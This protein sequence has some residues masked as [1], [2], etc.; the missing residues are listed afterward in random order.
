MVAAILAVLGLFV[1][2]TML[3]PTIRYLLAGEGTVGRVISALG[4][5]DEAPPLSPLGARAGR[6]LANLQEALPVFLTVALL[7]V[8]HGSGEGTATLGAWWFLA[9]R[10]LYVPAYLSGVPGL[11]SAM[12]MASWLGLGAMLASL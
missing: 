8:A 7:H 2:Q 6:A 4:P 12:W 9:A 11:R 1:A 3:S 5:R 10:V